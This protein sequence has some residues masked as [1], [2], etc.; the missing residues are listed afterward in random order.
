MSNFKIRN[1][2]EKDLPAI[3]NLLNQAYRGVYE[4]TPYRED[5]VR[6]WL[7]RGNAEIFVAE[8]KG[9]ILGVA[10]Y[11]DG[12]W[13]EEI[14]WL[15]TKDVV[16]KRAIEDALVKAIEKRVKG[17][18]VFTAVDVESPKI[19]EWVER[20]YKAEGG[21]YHMIAK[22]KGLK[23]IPKVPEGIILRSLKPEEE[24]AFVEAVNAGFGWERISVGAIQRWKDEHPPFNE[25]WIHVADAGCKIVSVVVSRPDTEYNEYYGGKRGYM[26]P[27]ATIPQY[28]GKGLACALTCRAMNFLY[29]RGYDSVA[30]YTAE[31][32]IPS[33]TLL[34]KLGF[35]VAHNWKFM[36]KN[37]QREPT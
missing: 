26:G 6:F 10:L 36:R 19:A 16:D 25:E 22:L 7:Q 17:S 3:V 34:Q 29:T 11:R 9:E 32:N 4:F 35:Q 8:V 21:L 1:F 18:A 23:P 2:E 33:V 14:E 15:A 12:H 30:L 28:R 20:G 24:K 5:D 27:A 31:Q 37:I 13:G